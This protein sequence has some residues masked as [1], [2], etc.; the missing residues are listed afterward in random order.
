MTSKEGIFVSVRFRDP[1]KGQALEAKSLLEPKGIPTFVVKVDAG[2]DIKEEVVS[3]LSSCRMV[4]IMGSADYG[5]PGTTS[6]GTDNEIEF[7][8]DNKI[9]Y[10]FVKMCDEFQSSRT[11]FNLPRTISCYHLAEGA[12]IPEDL[13]TEIV[14]KYNVSIFAQFKFL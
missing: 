2:G 1:V 9:K 13:I 4:L 5:V 6:Y 3:K 12:G 7:I 14:K 11:R 8:I 10:F